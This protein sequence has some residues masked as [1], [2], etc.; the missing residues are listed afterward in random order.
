MGEVNMNGAKKLG[1]LVAIGLFIL[2]AP[3]STVIVG[4]TSPASLWDFMPGATTPQGWPYNS[5]DGIMDWV[6]YYLGYVANGTLE[7][8]Y[9]IFSLGNTTTWT[10]STGTWTQRGWSLGQ[11]NDTSWKIFSMSTYR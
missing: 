7:P 10:T 5:G 1:V 4:G 3:V 6:R 2:T 11:G 8:T 9:R